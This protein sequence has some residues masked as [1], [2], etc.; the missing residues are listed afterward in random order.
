[1]QQVHPNMNNVKKN[2]KKR[3]GTSIA[4]RKIFNL[5]K[6]QLKINSSMRQFEYPMFGGTFELIYYY[7]RQY[8]LLEMPLKFLV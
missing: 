1:M 4:N 6:N 3:R 7:K 2:D 8:N 5:K